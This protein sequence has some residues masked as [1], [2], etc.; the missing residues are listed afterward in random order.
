MKTYKCANIRNIAI[1]GHGGSGKT[2]LA[3]ALLFKSGGIDR[4]GKI[5]DGNTV[6]DHDPEEIKR[7]I[8]LNISLA[9]TE[10]KNTKI[11]IVDT[12]GQFDFIGG[13]YE[14]IRAA[15]TVVIA[16]SAKDGVQVGTI[17]AFN[18]ATKQGK[19]KVFA[20]TKND[21][22]NADFAKTLQGLKTQFGGSVCELSDRDALSELVAGTDEALMEKYLDTGELS[23]DE[24]AK[25]LT[26]ALAGGDVAP[27]VSVS[28]LT[29]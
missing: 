24:F 14:G 26:A 22:E 7:K 23:E 20:V 29:G 17:K 10:F 19:A 3:E 5:S 9:Y 11:N 6:C 28:A 13:M 12:P 16:L 2:T 1:A 25:G 21:E 15:E 4:M 8:S 27:V 18:E